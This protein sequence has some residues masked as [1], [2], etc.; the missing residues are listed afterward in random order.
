MKKIVISTLLISLNYLTLAQNV[1]QIDTG[2]RSTYVGNSYIIKN[3]LRLL[4]G[5]QVSGSTATNGSFIAKAQYLDVSPEP[6]GSSDVD[7]DIT[8]IF[9]D[10]MDMTDVESKITI[11]G[12]QSGTIT[13]GSWTQNGEKITFDYADYFEDGEQITVTISDNLEGINDFWVP[14]TFS[15]HFNVS[16]QYIIFQ[17]MH[18][19]RPLTIRVL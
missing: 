15:W 8:M 19:K 2:T 14:Q 16:M 11:Q 9:T 17:M 7:A 4:P 3:S 1:E 10:V 6:N 12:S 18:L 5:F 13:S